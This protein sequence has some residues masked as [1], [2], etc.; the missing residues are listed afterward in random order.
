VTNKEACVIDETRLELV[1]KRDRIIVT[2]SLVG[3][4]AISWLYMLE[5]AEG[6]LS[7]G[8]NV[9]INGPHIQPW[10]ALNLLLTFV[11]WTVMMAAMMVP[12]ESPIILIFAA[13]QRRRREQLLPFVSTGAFLLGYLIAWT[14]YSALATLTQWGLDAAALLSPMMAVD[15]RILGGAFLF[16]AGAF[17]W[18]SLKYACLTR[19]RSPLSFLLNEWREG[20]A[21]AVVMGLKHGIYC[22]GCCWL[23][24]GLMFVAGVMNLLWMAII[25]VFVL[26]EKIVPGGFWISRIAGL[27]FIVWGALMVLGSLL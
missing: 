10:N 25:T 5:M 6:N 8:P 4:T 17:Q 2:L 16:A 9:C 23:L 7:V 1:Q 11:M 20:P 18:T 12:S 26:L 24:M 15:D 27:V 22:I 19:C 13:I 3:I 14:A 21:G